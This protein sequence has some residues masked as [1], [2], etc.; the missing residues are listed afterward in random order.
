MPAGASFFLFQFLLTAQARGLL[1]P[2]LRATGRLGFSCEGSSTFSSVIITGCFR[3][4]QAW[5]PS[6]FSKKVAELCSQSSFFF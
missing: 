6:A 5:C 3:A 2:T 1:L 4:K